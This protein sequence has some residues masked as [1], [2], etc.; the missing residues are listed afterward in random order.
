[1][2]KNLQQLT[3]AFSDANLQA[4]G[5]SM[6][7]STW[8]DIGDQVFLQPHNSS[9]DVDFNSVCTSVKQNN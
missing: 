1:M 6:S 4:N 3:L 8:L 7:E 9:L 5:A 2:F